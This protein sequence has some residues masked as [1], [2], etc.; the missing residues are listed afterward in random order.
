MFR[1]YFQA[2]QPDCDL[3]VYV[4]YS[5]RQWEFDLDEHGEEFVENDEGKVYRLIN[6]YQHDLT[7]QVLWIEVE[8]L[9]AYKVPEE[10]MPEEG[11]IRTKDEVTQMLEKI[12]IEKSYF[13]NE[14]RR[15][16]Q[17]YVAKIKDTL[18]GDY[19]EEYTLEH[20]NEIVEEWKDTKKYYEDKIK[21]YSRE[22]DVINWMLKLG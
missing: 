7:E 6:K 8:E 5:G 16:G 2:D 17:K 13:I 4:D 19:G 15:A 10:K 1:V 12:R 18:D 3:G 22:L 14:K 9:D 21:G 20:I 11:S